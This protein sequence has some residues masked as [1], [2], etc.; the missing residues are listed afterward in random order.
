M[1]SSIN[2][3]LPLD[4]VDAVKNELRANLGFAKAEIEAL[5]AAIAGGPPGG[6]YQPMVDIREFGTRNGTTDT[7][8]VK[9]ALT[10]IQTGIHAGRTLWVPA[11]VYGLTSP[12]WGSFPQRGPIRIRAEQGAIFDGGAVDDWW[13]NPVPTQNPGFTNSVLDGVR[14]LELDHL[15][16]TTVYPGLTEAADGTVL[17]QT[18]PDQILTIGYPLDIEGLTFRRWTQAFKGLENHDHVVPFF[19][20][21]NCRFEECYRGIVTWLNAPAVYDRILLT[22][23]TFYRCNVGVA[24]EGTRWRNVL[25]HG[26]YADLCARE[27]IRFGSNEDEEM[28]F[29]TR[30]IYSFNCVSR[31]GITALREA[32]QTLQI[33]SN[34]VHA[35]RDY[36]EQ[37]AYISNIC[38]DVDAGAN[39]NDAEVIYT[40]ARFTTAVGNILLSPAGGGDSRALFAKKGGSRSKYL[41]PDD[42]PGAFEQTLAFACMYS[43]NIFWFAPNLAAGLGGPGFFSES[44]DFLLVDNWFENCGDPGAHA[45]GGGS[46]QNSNLDQNLVIRGNY[47][48][49]SRGRIVNAR[50]EG[51]RV[52]I[53]HNTIHVSFAPGA[54]VRHL[55]IATIAG[56]GLGG[57]DPQGTAGIQ[58]NTPT[59]VHV[60][61]NNGDGGSTEEVLAKCDQA[62]NAHQ[63]IV[64][65]NSLKDVVRWVGP[66]NG[67]L[68]RLEIIDNDSHGSTAAILFFIGDVNHAPKQLRIRGNR[69][70]KRV[71]AAATAIN[72]QRL[73]MPTNAVGAVKYKL[74]GRNSTSAADA[75]YAELTQGIF[76]GGLFGT[77]NLIEFTRG[78]LTAG[79]ANILQ[80]GSTTDLQIVPPT[81][82]TSFTWDADID[83]YYEAP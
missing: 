22:Y 25:V 1:V 67:P 83:V 66:A 19:R 57:T 75:Y 28:R 35:I 33:N 68:K 13:N 74:L 10:A 30:V 43:G 34:E 65:G 51:G 3:A 82:T 6:A 80:S 7:T 56:V 29:F 58:Y 15:P 21:S 64:E 14:F 38:Y 77:Q 69:N 36:S 2:S 72:V 9:N 40:K 32:G 37:V 70:L 42:P 12:V 54:P 61:W 23:N 73:F 16:G 18:L 81:G 76:Q 48:R 47:F 49:G 5:Q 26:N 78:L 27:G 24:W 46:S 55:G 71:T 39:S 44:G 62:T 31:I 50:W 60:R 8:M 17:T 52:Y 41:S 53:E 4:N 59:V 79:R 20:I 63:I 11:G 45:I